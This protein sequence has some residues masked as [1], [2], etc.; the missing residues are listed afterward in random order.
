MSNGEATAGSAGKATIYFQGGYGMSKI[1]VSSVEFS[2]QKYAQYAAAY[3]I[4][5]VKKGCRSW[6]GTVVSDHPSYLIVEGW[7]HPDVDSAFGAAV[8]S[9]NGILVSKGRYSSC[10]PRWLSD[11]DKKINP[12]IERT[13][14]KVV[15]DLRGHDPHKT[16]A[17][18][19]AAA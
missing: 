6:V 15:L 4:K 10:D 14:A 8:E 9:E 1:E 11:F 5:W 2:E 16:R 7:G 19:A 13:G 3:Q 17:V 12:Y 18:V